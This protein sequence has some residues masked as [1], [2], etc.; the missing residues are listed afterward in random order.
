M[1]NTL[2][3]WQRKNPD[4]VWVYCEPDT[5]AFIANSRPGDVRLTDVPVQTSIVFRREPRPH[6]RLITANRVR[7]SEK[8]LVRDVEK[9]GLFGHL[10][11]AGQATAIERLQDIDECNLRHEWER[12]LANAPAWHWARAIL[13]MLPP[14]L[15]ARIVYRWNAGGCP[16]NASYFVTHVRRLAIESGYDP[17]N[18]VRPTWWPTSET[19]PKA[20][21]APAPLI[22]VTV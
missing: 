14:E 15:R 12:R 10:V 17:D 16:K 1:S 7:H 22:V 19:W 2:T 13:R 6:R 8:A 5:A 4:G 3:V 20:R 11:K 21:P 9:A 18:M